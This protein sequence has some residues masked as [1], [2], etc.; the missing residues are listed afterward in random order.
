VGSRIEDIVGMIHQR[1]IIRLEK[2]VY[3]KPGQPF[4]ITI[5]TQNKVIL[6]GKL[7]ELLFRSV[8]EGDMRKESD[9]MAVCVMDDHVH[10]LLA[11]IR[12]NLINL[13]GRWKSYTT[14][15]I[16]LRERIGKLWQRSF[17]DHGVRKDEDLIKVAEYIVSNPVRKGFAQS[18]REYPFAW[19][20]WM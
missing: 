20:K 4:S 15:L 11:P 13:I 9:L 6:L 19:H 1:E 16:K 2:E 3:E 7:K 14:H 18:W 17:Y 5:C 12:E 8:I 10:F